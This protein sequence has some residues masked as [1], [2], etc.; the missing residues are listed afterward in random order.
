[1]SEGGEGGGEGSGGGHG[2]GGHSEG[3]HESHGGEDHGS[4]EHS[5]DGYEGG[6]GDGHDG[7]HEE[8]HGSDKH[9][10]G[11]EEKES[12]ITS[13]EKDYVA[14]LETGIDEK[15]MDGLV[16]K[17][18]NNESIDYT[19]LEISKLESQVKGALAKMPHNTSRA[20]KF[21]NYSRLLGQIAQ[22]GTNTLLSNR[23]ARKMNEHTEH[24]LEDG[25][26]V[27]IYIHG[28][29]QS[30]ANQVELLKLAQ[31]QGKQVIT[32]EH[33]FNEDFNSVGEKLYHFIKEIAGRTSARVT[34]IGHS[35]GGKIALAA[36]QKFGAEQY[37]NK[38]VL[39]ESD[40]NNM[41][42]ASFKKQPLYPMILPFGIPDEALL[43]NKSGREG[44][45]GRYKMAA[46]VPV[47]QV[48]G[49][50][51]G[52][53]DGLVPVESAV[54]TRANRTYFDADAT[55]FTYAG[56]DRAGNEKILSFADL[57][58]ESYNK[59]ADKQGREAYRWSD[60]KSAN[61]EASSN[62]HFRSANKNIS[63]MT[64]VQKKEDNSWYKENNPR[65]AELN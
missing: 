28:W 53:G 40:V 12:G 26:E 30:I 51:F 50:G 17:L 3:G 24:S 14:A 10:H 65:K 29:Q 58:W 31:Q 48:I 6:H 16:A 39:I 33:D 23:V 60:N 64:R 41:R 1:M 9:G 36:A 37:V 63:N 46:Q 19:E 18:R 38:V 32:Y 54:Y 49:T 20:Q 15:E 55:H 45:L 5:G 43:E 35:D 56:G 42:E 21:R 47:Y 52:K 7:G 59:A 2:E 22:N 44:A 27:I 62:S 34:L 25:D 13:Y 61:G 8:G 57:G 11:G 4:H